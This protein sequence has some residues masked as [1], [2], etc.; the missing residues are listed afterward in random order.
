METSKEMLHTSLVKID[1]EILKDFKQIFDIK[2][3]N[4]ENIYFLTIDSFE[5]K[6][7]KNTGLI[8]I[9]TNLSTGEQ[10]IYNNYKLGKDVPDIEIPNIENYNIVQ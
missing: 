1:N 3:K 7:N 9:I 8:E 4:Y 5:Y 10:Y 6:I 2:I